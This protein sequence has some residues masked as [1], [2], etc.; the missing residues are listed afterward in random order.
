MG[1]FVVALLL[2]T[3]GT[4]WWL[5]VPGRHAF[6]IDRS[7]WMAPFVDC[8]ALL[9]FHAAGLYVGIVRERRAARGIG[10]VVAIIGWAAAMSVPSFA[11]A[12]TISA[13][14]TVVVA[15]GAWARF[16]N[17]DFGA[18]PLWG[19]MANVAVGLGAA[20]LVVSA[21]LGASR[22]ATARQQPFT[23]RSPLPPWPYATI[24]RDG[25][26]ELLSRQEYS[27]F[28]EADVIGSSQI[29]VDQRSVNAVVRRSYRDARLWVT[30]LFTAFREGPRWYYQRRVGLIS[31]HD[32]RT[33]ALLGW[34]GPDGYSEGANMPAGRFNGKLQ[35]TGIQHSLRKG[36]LIL[37]TSVY[38]LDELSRPILI[39]RAPEGETIL[40]ASQG[41]LYSGGASPRGDAPWG[42][43]SVFTTATHTYVVDPGGRVQLKV[44]NPRAD[45]NRVVNVYRAPYG[46]GAPTFVWFRPQEISRTDSLNEVFEFRLGQGQV[47]E[48]RFATSPLA[49]SVNVD[50]DG[51]RSLSLTAGLPLVPV[52]QAYA[53]TREM[54]PSGRQAANRALLTSVLVCLGLAG[55]VFWMCRRHAFTSRE[56]RTWTALTALL[57]P[58]VLAVMWLFVEWPARESCPACSRLRVVSRE[59]CEHC[60]AGFGARRKTIGWTAAEVAS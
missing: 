4:M 19:R 25:R 10:V 29:K 43:F 13:V 39:A 2:A 42:W 17:P 60:S 26:I 5:A 58:M 57:G 15:A 30:P 11:L 37:N 54:A 3:V 41:E 49:Y 9:T 28:V 16:T 18:Q 48:R 21:L 53:L 46:A 34:L 52:A 56:T 55:L 8:F 7:F 6:P 33:G 1:A 31:I 20:A 23:T 32:R 12:I 38:A 27:R 44:A 47:A 45:S 35:T 14:F 24:T 51:P 22:F 40:G 50:G 59:R 36:L